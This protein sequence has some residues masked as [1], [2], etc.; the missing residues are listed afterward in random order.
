[1]VQVINDPLEAKL[2]NT[3][4]YEQY[5][6]YMGPIQDMLFGFYDLRGCKPGANTAV[7]LTDWSKRKTG[8]VKQRF[9]DDSI[10]FKLLVK[11]DLNEDC[12]VHIEKPIYPDCKLIH[13]P[14]RFFLKL[15]TGFRYFS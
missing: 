8:I 10:T 6:F 2:L 7:L 3:N 11:K 15:H 9:H 1:M 12:M 4:I 13:L 14:Q 5:I